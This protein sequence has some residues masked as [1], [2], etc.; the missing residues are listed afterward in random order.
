MM[1]PEQIAEAAACLDTAEKTRQQIGLLSLAYPGMTMDDAYAVQ[2]EWVR[3]K[4]AAG[5]TSIGWK[6][7]LTSKA[8]QY[9]LN[10]DIPDSGVLLD[11]MLFDD[12][13]VVPDHRF[14]QPRIEAEIA[15]IMKKDLSGPG[16]SVFDVL[17]ATDYITPALEILDT[18]ILRV[19][20]QTNKSRTIVDTISDNAANAGIVLGGRAMRPDAVDMRWM[21]AIVSRNAEVEETG[22]GAGVLNNPARGI[23][24]LANRL[25]QYGARIEAG[26]VVLA[27]SFIRPVE[28]RH[29]DTITSDFG[30]YGTVSCYFA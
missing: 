8:M 7:G 6:I 28:A 4:M 22:L 12:G 26:Q 14:I 21:G 16:V 18:R 15:F 25:H 17:N 11:D 13:S 2:A 27:G 10:I 3:L 23:A 24:W 29:G 1:T 20:P 5:R 30:A 19:D 9:A